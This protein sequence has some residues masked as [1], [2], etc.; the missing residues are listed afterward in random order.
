MVKF[1]K[2][3][4]APLISSK[5]TTEHLWVLDHGHIS[6]SSSLNRLS[7]YVNDSYEGFSY[8]DRH[9]IC[10]AKVVDLLYATVCPSC[11]QIYELGDDGTRGLYATVALRCSSACGYQSRRLPITRSMMNIYMQI[12]IQHVVAIIDIQAGT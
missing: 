3:R 6:H 4:K 7:M 8:I 10:S 2:T 5:M 12:R 11:G 9:S 1:D